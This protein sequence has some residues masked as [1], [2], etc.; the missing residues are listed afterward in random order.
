M[1]VGS[2]T[3]IHDVFKLPLLLYEVIYFNIILDYEVTQFFTQLEPTLILI[4][5]RR[6]VV[7]TDIKNASNFKKFWL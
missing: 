4:T 6:R 2:Y 5:S 7:K 1:A 3:Q